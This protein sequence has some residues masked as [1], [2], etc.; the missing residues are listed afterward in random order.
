MFEGGVSVMWQSLHDG[1]QRISLRDLLKKRKSGREE[2]RKRGR[3]EAVGQDRS[4][5]EER[6]GQRG[7]GGGTGTEKETDQ[8]VHAASSVTKH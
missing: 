4:T 2:G 1:N 6:S 8:D 3:R 5:Q 7:Q